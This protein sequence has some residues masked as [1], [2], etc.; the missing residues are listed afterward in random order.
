MSEVMYNFGF[1]LLITELILLF[2]PFHNINKGIIFILFGV[3]L[4]AGTPGNKEFRVLAVFVQACVSFDIFEEGFE[5]I[6]QLL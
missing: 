5:L 6:E 1:V 4:T 2:S 3:G